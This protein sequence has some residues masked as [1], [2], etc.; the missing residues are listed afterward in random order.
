MLLYVCLAQLTTPEEKTKFELLY[1]K[2][3]NLMFHIAYSI[4]NRE[5]EAENCLQVAFFNIANNFDGV[6]DID[7]NTTKNWVCVI[8]KNVALNMLKNM[9]KRNEE[10]LSD[11]IEIKFDVSDVYDVSDANE[12]K[13]IIASMPEK[14]RDI[15]EFVILYG[16]DYKTISKEF[17]I[18]EASAR[19]RFER[20][21]AMLLSLLEEK[22]YAVDGITY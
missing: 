9:N 7:A 20:A 13:S 19:K 14:Y 10:I 17:C 2:Y 21:K 11:D 15:L 18:S 16:K 6:A 5:D 4:L 8:A 1:E 22:G 3:K 12:I